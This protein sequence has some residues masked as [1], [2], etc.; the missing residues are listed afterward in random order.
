M[1]WHIAR[2]PKTS[3]KAYFALQALTKKKC[4]ARIVQNSTPT[5][6]PTYT[7][8]MENYKKNRNERMDFFFCNDDIKHCV[9]G[10][11]RK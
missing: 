7:S 6:T 8:M 5:A 3:A 9:M 1:G 2:L 11:K 10:T 4:T